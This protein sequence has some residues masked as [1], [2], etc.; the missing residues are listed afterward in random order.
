MIRE[1]APFGLRNRN[2]DVLRCIAN[3]SND[4]VFTPPDL[5]KEMLDRVAEAWAE[6]NG[7]ASIWSDKSVRF[8]DPC[9]KSGIFLR[10]VAS[11]LIEG[12]EAEIPDLEER[13]D[14]VLTRQLFGIGITRLTGLI[15]RRSI[16]CSKWA[17]GPHSVAK[18]FSSDAG[19]VW[20]EST[21]HTWVDA[22]EYVET[23]D[24]SGK[25]VRKGIN[26][27][28]Q[29]CG[30]SQ[31]T[32]D[33]GADLET[34]AYA[35][36]H[37]TDI[38]SRMTEIFGAEMHFDVIIGNPPYQLNDGG[39]GT[40]AAPI[41]HLFVE[42]AKKLEPRFLCMIIPARW[43][44]GGKGLDAFRESMLAD[45]RLVVIEDYPD[46][47]DVFPGTQIKGG[48]CYFLW[49]R[50]AKGGQVRV[51]THD[52]GAVISSAVRPLVEPGADVFIRYNEGIS[53]LR[54]VMKAETGS[55]ATLALPTTKQFSALVSSR[56]P[57]GFDTTFRGKPTQSK[58]DVKLYRNGGIG[59]V[60]RSEIL[61]GKDVI[62]RW[63]VFLAY[64]G[65]GSDAFPHSILPRPFI[66]EPGSVSSETYLYIGPFN[67]KSETQNVCTYIATRLVRFLVLLHKPSQ[68]ATRP[69]YTF[70]PIQDFSKPWTDEELYSLY[71]ISEDE[72]VFIESMVR[73]MELDS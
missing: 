65:S 14:H 17:N 11:R 41:Y 48:I 23:A 34:H 45:G 4:E 59:Y 9:T 58:G 36:L 68:H 49:D 29:F 33:R 57:F 43:F 66:G 53:I 64:A 5:A 16:Y 69:V 56:K 51:T 8:L 30:A 39:Y 46:S 67:S 31:K 55:T 1:Q 44:A 62:D 40:S 3:L 19:N 54:K 22:T 38:K 20:F 32:L 63:K 71:G 61:N 12:L 6:A 10:E 35:F 50:D 28:C 18:S 70:V 73:P 60:S 47:N 15:A 13:V 7:G 27:R 25:P 21:R 42:Q 37:T 72:I 26:G 2:P 52:K 24:K